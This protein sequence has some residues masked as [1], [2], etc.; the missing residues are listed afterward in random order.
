MMTNASMCGIQVEPLRFKERISQKR[1]KSFRSSFLLLLL[2]VAWVLC[3]GAEGVEIGGRGGVSMGEEGS[4]LGVMLSGSNTGKCTVNGAC[5]SSL[6]YENNEQCKFATVEGGVLDVVS[7]DVESE[8]RCTP[9]FTPTTGN[10]APA[11]NASGLTTDE[12]KASQMEVD[13][14]CSTFGS[15]SGKARRGHDF[16]FEDVTSNNCAG[17]VALVSSKAGTIE[18]TTAGAASAKT[19]GAT[20][21]FALAPNVYER[22]DDDLEMAMLYSEWNDAGSDE[23]E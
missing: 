2:F 19:A 17:A 18:T 22:D 8:S 3:D 12:M 16:V 7:F 20:D 5:Y 21:T 15:S 9:E 1:M 23:G 13:H 14:Y 10:S 4:T 6:D 11:K